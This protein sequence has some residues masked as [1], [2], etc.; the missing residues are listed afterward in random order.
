MIKNKCKKCDILDSVL[1]QKIDIGGKTGEIEKKKIW[2]LVN[3]NLLILGFLALT[4]VP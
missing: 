2:A 1:E 3:R 4:N